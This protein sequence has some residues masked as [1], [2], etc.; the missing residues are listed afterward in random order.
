MRR[1]LLPVPLALLLA[2]CGPTTPLS[3]RDRTPGERA[4][5][6]A[7]CDAADPVRCALPF[8]SNTC[9]RADDTTRTGLRLAFDGSALTVREDASL[10]NHADGFSRASPLL[11]A[12]P[13]AVDAARANRRRDAVIAALRALG[14]GERVL[15]A[16]EPAAPLRPGVAPRGVTLTLR[17]AE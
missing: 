3:P 11:T 17:V 1:S 12:F 9:A 14:V 4:P 16:G 5:L 10:L 13:A 8:P 7:T 6:T 2:G 15:R